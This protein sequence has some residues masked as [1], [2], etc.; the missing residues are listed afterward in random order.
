MSGHPVDV[1]DLLDEGPFTP[2][3]ASGAAGVGIGIAGEQTALTP[4]SAEFAESLG[5][6]LPGLDL[7][8]LE[9]ILM[10][11]DGW[12]ALDLSAA[13][14]VVAEAEPAAHKAAQTRPS[15]LEEEVKPEIKEVPLDAS[16]SPLCSS[17]SSSSASATAESDSDGSFDSGLLASSS[18]AP[19][20]N[21]DMAYSG[22]MGTYNVTIKREPLEAVISAASAPGPSG[23]GSGGP[24]ART[25]NGAPMRALAASASNCGP[26]EK[27]EEKVGPPRGLMPPKPESSSA[28]KQ[29]V[30][31]ASFALP[32]RGAR[33]PI[34]VPNTAGAR[35]YSAGLVLA[36][37]NC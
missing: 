13:A 11:G 20:A 32:L 9:S 36:L 4:G 8:Q 22:M 31:P 27:A 2:G 21:M 5:S 18:S 1:S 23:S 30:P 16:S 24:H 35:L 15:A 26:D 28:G 12:L 10:C 33:L 37:L 29:L 14:G 17:S 34:I 7:S 6:M 19:S 3:V 25:K